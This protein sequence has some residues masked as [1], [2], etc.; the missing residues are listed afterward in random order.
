MHYI[1]LASVWKEKLATINLVH[2]IEL[3]VDNF[4]TKSNGCYKVQ[5]HI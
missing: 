2:V 4:V 1:P 5:F 3:H